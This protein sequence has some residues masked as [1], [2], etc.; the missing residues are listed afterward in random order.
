MRNGKVYS[1][2]I[3]LTKAYDSVW[4]E[5]MFAKLKSLNIDGKFLEIIK[6]IYEKSNR[7]AKIQSKITN[8]SNAKRGVRQR[9]PLS[10]ILFNISINDIAYKLEGINLAQLEL[11][12]VTLVSCL[13]YADDI[14][15]YLPEI[16]K[17][18]KN[19]FTTLTFIATNGKRQ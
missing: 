11:P 17:G 5:G 2:F 10:P 12:N 4:Q 1:C 9:C 3:D 19:Y 8:F 6:N 18:Y 7:V 16:Q 13:I 14:L 15:L